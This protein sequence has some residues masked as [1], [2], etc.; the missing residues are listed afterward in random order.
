MNVKFA[1]KHLMKKNNSKFI[2]NQFMRPKN[3]LNASIATKVLIKNNTSKSTSNQFMWGE[4][5]L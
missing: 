4:E 2:F 3:V 1:M 5:T